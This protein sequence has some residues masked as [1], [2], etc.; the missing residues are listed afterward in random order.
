MKWIILIFSLF[1]I[2]ALTL[3]CA[4]KKDQCAK[5][6]TEKVPENHNDDLSDNCSPFCFCTCCSI[7]V[8][9]SCY[10]FDCKPIPVNEITDFSIIQSHFAGYIPSVWQPPKTI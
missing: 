5:I 4:D 6:H 8:V 10:H 2:Y 7:I 1:I 9:L 3:P